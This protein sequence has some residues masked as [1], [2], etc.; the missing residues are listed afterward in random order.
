MFK[1]TKREGPILKGNGKILM[2]VEKIKNV[3]IQGT[4]VVISR[5]YGKWMDFTASGIIPNKISICKPRTS[6]N[7]LLDSTWNSIAH[8]CLNLDNINHYT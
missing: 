7:L 4:L 6:N 5:R 8:H 2:Y 1:V 3:E